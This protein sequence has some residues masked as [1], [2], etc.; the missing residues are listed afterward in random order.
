MLM[1]VHSLILVDSV[2][3]RCEQVP[4]VRFTI[5]LPRLTDPRNFITALLVTQEPEETTLLF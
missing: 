3:C 1:G 2:H 4:F 5:I